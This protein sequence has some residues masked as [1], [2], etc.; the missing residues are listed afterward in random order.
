MKFKSI[1]FIFILAIATLFATSCSNRL[2]PQQKYFARQEKK[3]KKENEKI[4]A[5][6]HKHH[7]NIQPDRTQNMMDKSKKRSKN[8]NKKKS[9]SWVD[10]TFKRKRSKSCNGN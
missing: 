9:G 1:F 3:M 5:D 10:R 4:V 8:M 2:T 6:F 7:Y